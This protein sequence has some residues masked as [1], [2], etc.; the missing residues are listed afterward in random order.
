MQELPFKM[1]PAAQEQILELHSKL[2][3]PFGQSDACMHSEIEI[4]WSASTY[5]NYSKYRCPRNIVAST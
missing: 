3:P 1:K 4:V 5:R 2:M